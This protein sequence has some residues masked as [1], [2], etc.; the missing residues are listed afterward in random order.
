MSMKHTVQPR[1][2]GIS[3]LVDQDA[4]VVIELDNTAIWPLK[5]LPCPDD[6]GVPNISSPDLVRDANARRAS[7]LGAE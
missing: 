2:D 6:H 5:F 1:P 3:S 7:R 4:S